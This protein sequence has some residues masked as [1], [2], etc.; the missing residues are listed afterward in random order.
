[1]N[2]MYLKYRFRTFELSLYNVGNGMNPASLNRHRKHRTVVIL[3][4]VSL[5]SRDF[6]RRVYKIRVNYDIGLHQF[7]SDTTPLPSVRFSLSFLESSRTFHLFWSWKGISYA[8]LTSVELNGITWTY[9]INRTSL[10]ISKLRSNGM[11]Q[12]T[13]WS[14]IER[15]TLDCA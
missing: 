13:K 3:N 5:T 15:S 8:K 2:G 7:T 4:Y 6:G 11:Q 14:K 12:L 1:M 9:D 10:K